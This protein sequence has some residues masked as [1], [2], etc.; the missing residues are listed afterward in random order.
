MTTKEQFYIALAE[1]IDAAT[2]VVQSTDT[3]YPADS[4]YI[5]ELRLTLEKIK[6]QLKQDPN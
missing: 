1:L 2:N 6:L 4:Y 3:G 5:Y